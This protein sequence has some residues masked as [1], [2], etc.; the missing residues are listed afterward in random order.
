MGVGVVSMY[1]V[2]PSEGSALFVS[3]VKFI[4]G[5]D[6]TANWRGG[7][8]DGRTGGAGTTAAWK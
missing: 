8:G 7:S 6:S 4:E 5:A 3:V 2:L 1:E